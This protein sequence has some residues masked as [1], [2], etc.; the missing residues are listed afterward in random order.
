[1]RRIFSKWTAVG[2]VVL[3]AAIMSAV[4]TASKAAS[5]QVCVLLPDTKSSVRWQD[6]DAPDFAKALKAAGVTYL[7]TNALNDPAKQKAQAQAC[8]QAGAKVVIETALDA[9][10]AAAIEKLFTSSGGKAIDYDRQ[11]AGGTASVYVSFDGKQV[12]VLQAQ[13]VLSGLKGKTKPVVAELWGGKTDANAFLFKSGNDAVLNPLFAKGTIKKGPQQF[14]PGW[15]ATNAAPIFSQM[16]VS[17]NNKIDG[18]IAANDNIAGAVV[19]TLQA[20]HLKPIALSG[21]DATAQGVQNIISG[22]QT[23]TVFKFVPLEAAAAAKAAVQLLKG[24]KLTGVNAY[25]NATK[26]ACSPKAGGGSEPS[27]LIPPTAITKAN[28]TILFKQKFLKKSDVCV[29]KFKQYCK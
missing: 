2:L 5:V 26:N 20:R 21:Q 3:A 15:L 23:M 1:M 6:F 12:G 22:W 13:G 28:Y 29:G 24:Q 27:V 4:A 10:S 19:A 14:V 7:I 25:C 18:S 16:L 9:G 8:L 17:T 11:V